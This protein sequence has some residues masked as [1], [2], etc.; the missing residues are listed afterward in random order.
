MNIVKN[1][2]KVNHALNSQVPRGVQRGD[3]VLGKIVET[4]DDYALLD[5]SCKTE[6]LLPCEEFDEQCIVGNTIDVLIEKNDSDTGMIL[7]SKEKAQ[8]IKAIN[9]AYMAHRNNAPVTG[10]IAAEGQDGFEVLLDI[11]I[12]A[13]LPYHLADRNKI[14]NRK[15]Y[16]NQSCDFLISKIIK[17]K[18][19][20]NII[21]SRRE[22]VGEKTNKAVDALLS[23][24]KVGDIVEGVVTEF[25][26][27]GAFVDIED[28]TALLHINELSWLS[29]TQLN[30]V[31]KVGQKIKC[32]IINFDKAQNKIFLSIRQITPD[33][34]INIQKELPL[35]KVIEGII[36]VIKEYG[37]FISIDGK[38]EGLIH[39][40]EIS[41]DENTKPLHQ[42]FS[43]KQKISAKVIRINHEERK[44]ALSHRRTQQSP[45]DK[46]YQENKDQPLDGTVVNILDTGLIIE[47][48]NKL[49][50]FLHYSQISW[51]NVRYYSK[52][53]SIGQK[54]TTGIVSTSSTKEFLKLSSKILQDNPWDGIN[55]AYKNKQII[56]VD[57]VQT[58]KEGVVVSLMKD[59]HGFIHKTHLIKQ[60]H[61][62]NGHDSYHKGDQLRVIIQEVNFSNHRVLLSE[63]IR[64]KMESRE[65]IDQYLVLEDDKLTSTIGDHIQ[66]HKK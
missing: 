5:I 32:K 40:S 28:C 55:D 42:R 56:V 57:V 43:R 50:G 49:R 17:H 66:S 6:G 4:N 33:P 18:K 44:I 24:Y 62:K 23:K 16:L 19:E 14:R 12:T 11:G 53:F 13:Q 26:Y 65:Q 47:F 64:E 15:K 45:C 58:V 48:P 34:W 63:R 36:E 9:D 35:G 27:Y 8:K 51:G 30:D 39:I 31:L 54:I 41:W 7:V 29:S 1:E 25:L 46:M 61:A 2:N 20:T 59:I 21:L 38:Y 3:I 10:T 52:D 37:L 22:L 60:I